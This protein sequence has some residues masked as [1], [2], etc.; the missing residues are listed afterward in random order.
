[1][2]T[3][4]LMRNGRMTVNGKDIAYR[5]YAVDD[6]YSYVLDL[7]EINNEVHNLLGYLDSL[8]MSAEDYEYLDEMYLDESVYCAAANGLLPDV[9]EYCGIENVYAEAE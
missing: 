2:A 7:F 8:P 9:A 5:I 1:M 3:P 6:L 4:L